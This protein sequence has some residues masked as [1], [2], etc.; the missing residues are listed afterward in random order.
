MSRYVLRDDLSFCDVAGQLV[1]LDIGNDRYFRLL[2][3]MER[4][5]IAHLHNDPNADISGLIEQTILVAQEGASIDARPSIEPVAR[6][7]MEAPP[8]EQKPSA[9]EFLDVFQMVIAARLELKLSPLRKI[10]DSVSA[11]SHIRTAHSEAPPE[12]LESRLEDAAAAFRQARLYVPVEM[13]CLLDAIAMARFL[14][15]RNL[16]AHIVFGVALDP[17]SAHCWV[18]AGDLVLNDTVGNVCAHTPIRVV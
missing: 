5:L 10:L 14:R 6:S 8:P 12:R 4:A 17:F 16:H 15:R 11:T 7:A 18:Q 9:R 1:F 13:S 2:P 3:P